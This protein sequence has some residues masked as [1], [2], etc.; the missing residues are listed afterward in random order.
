MQKK[1]AQFAGHGPLSPECQ[2]MLDTNAAISS[3][4][5]LALADVPLEALLKQTLQVIMSIPWLSLDQRGCIFVVENDPNVLVMKVQSKLAEPIRRAC[6]RIA[7]GTCLCGRAALKQTVQFASHVDDRHDISYPGMASHGHFCVPIVYDKST[8]GVVNLY[9]N[10]GH[11][12]VPEEEQFLSSTADSLA[13]M[14]RRKSVERQLVQSNENLR[15]AIAGTIRLMVSTVELR[16]PYTAG[17]Q[18][19]VADIAAKIAA[20]TGFS[21]DRIEAIRV[22][23][24][25]HDIGKISVPVEILSK[26]GSITVHEAAIIQTHCQVGYDLLKTIEFPWPIAEIVWQHHERMDG[27]GYPQGLRGDDI[28]AEARILAVADVFEAMCSHRPYRSSLGVDNALAEIIRHKGD[29]YDPMVVDAL[30]E[31]LAD[32]SSELALAA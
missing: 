4:L 22:A 16:D 1:Q 31:V 7:F 30:L 32:D 25:V 2:R 15:K 12:R 26:S 24:S 3:L 23:A 19:R 17:H 9:V 14:L 6:K 13:G 8:L 11:R 18:R 28:Q 29:L 27:S 21:E 10:A 20:K 5:R